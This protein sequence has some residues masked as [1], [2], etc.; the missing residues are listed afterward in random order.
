MPQY[1]KRK[2]RK[3]NFTPSH[4]LTF[5]P[6]HL[7]TLSLSHLLTLSPFH[8]LTLSLSHPIPHTL[9]PSQGPEHCNACR[10]YFIE[11]REG[12]DTV[13]RCVG[14][15]PLGTYLIP[16]SRQCA[17]CHEACRAGCAGPLPSVNN[18]HGCLE[19]DRVRLN[20]EGRQVSHHIPGMALYPWSAQ[21][22]IHFTLSPMPQEICLSS[23]CTAG[24]YS[25]VLMTAIGDLNPGVDVCIPCDPL[26]QV[27]VGPGTGLADCP[28]C[29]FAARPMEGCVESCNATLGE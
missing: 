6:S 8:S 24:T 4:S 17:S 5:S 28:V 23:G 12:S 27:C 25:S 9:S 20:R 13:R 10:N 11:V 16:S 15:C 18:T 29:T 7:L 21:S 19:C 3:L 22:R 1:N 2:Y 14:E 26:C